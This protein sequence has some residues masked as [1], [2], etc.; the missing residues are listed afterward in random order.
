MRRLRLQGKASIPWSTI[1]YPLDSDLLSGWH[2]PF[3]CN[4]D[5]DSTALIHAHLCVEAKFN[6]SWIWYFSWVHS[7]YVIIPNL[8]FF[9]NLIPIFQAP[10]MSLDGHPLSIMESLHSGKGCEKGKSSLKIEPSFNWPPS[11]TRLRELLMY[12]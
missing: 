7:H 9:L 3:L 11:P 6:Y 12:W 1:M 2:Y 10:L 4:N 5:P 8:D